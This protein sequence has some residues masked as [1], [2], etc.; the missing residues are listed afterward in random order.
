L[1]LIHIRTPKYYY[2]SCGKVRNRARGRWQVP[3]LLNMR[4]RNS[5][6][7]VALK[8]MKNSSIYLTKRRQLIELEASAPM[9][10]IRRNP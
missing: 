2:K 1:V 8:L 3:N 9:K 5:L 4:S 7:K 6:K 10:T